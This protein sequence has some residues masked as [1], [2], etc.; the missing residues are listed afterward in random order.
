[1]VTLTERLQA[2]IT[3]INAEIDR[4]KAQAITQVNELQADRALFQQ[5]LAVLVKAPEIE[6]LLPALQKLGAI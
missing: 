1:M 2:R 6:Q 3:A 5:A 4:V